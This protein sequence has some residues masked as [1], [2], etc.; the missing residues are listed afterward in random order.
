M[1]GHSKLPQRQ[2]HFLAAL[3]SQPSVSMAAKQARISETT[4]TRWL[5]DASF[6]AAYDA[7][8]QQLLDEVIRFLQQSMLAA[9][10]SLRQV[11]LSDQTRPAQKIMAARSILELGFQATSIEALTKRIEALEGQKG[12]TS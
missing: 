11:M 12:A 10:A 1:P 8:K 5:Q 6:K 3:L 4:A 7:A 9:A 2:A